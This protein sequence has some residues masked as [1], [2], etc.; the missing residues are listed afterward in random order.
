MSGEYLKSRMTVPASTTVS[1]TTDAG[2]PTVVTLTAANKYI[3]TL[4]SDFESQLNS[5]QPPTSG[6]WEV[7]WSETTGKVSITCTGTWSIAFTST[8]LRDALGFTGDLTSV[9]GTQ[10]G[11]RQ[12]LGVWFPMCPLMLDGDPAVAPRLD[13]GRSTVGPSGEVYKVAGVTSYRLKNIRFEY[14]PAA[15]VWAGRATTVNADYET[16]Y[17]T[18]QAGLGHA[19]WSPASPTILYWQNGGLGLYE[20]GNGSVTAWKFPSPQ[21]LDEVAM[22]SAPWT[23]YATIVLGDARSAG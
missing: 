22:A 1:V 18:T 16:Y 7:T 8:N 10:T 5:T 23:G 19:W 3:D 9:T 20:L 4:C 21:T 11:T 12:A 15:Q 13:D 6:S 14:V 17:M 2:G